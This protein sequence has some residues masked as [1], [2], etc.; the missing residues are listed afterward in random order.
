MTNEQKFEVWKTI[1]LG[2]GLKTADDFRRALKKGG[3]RISDW[4]DDILGKPAFTA[5]EQEMEVDLVV[6]SVAELGF[7][8][9]ACRRDIYKRAQELGLELCPAEVGPQLRLQYKDQPYGERLLTGMEPITD[10]DGYL[11]GFYV[12][13][14]GCRQWLRSFVGNPDCFWDGHRRWVFLRCKPFDKNQDK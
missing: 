3:H 2:T 12:E 10:S 13:H 14:D 1:K 7:K 11:Y 4:S 9:G 5:S 8:D 6:A